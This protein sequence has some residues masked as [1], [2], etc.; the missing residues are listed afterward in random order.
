MVL[1]RCCLRS[2]D[3]DMTGPQ[4]RSTVRNAPGIL[5]DDKSGRYVVRVR[6]RQGKQLSKTFDK[7]SDAKD[8]QAQ[9]RLTP[10]TQARRR[11]MPTFAAYADTIPEMHP[12]WRPGTVEAW[13]SR[14]NRVRDDLGPIRLDV[15][16]AGDVR[17]A[18]A[19]MQVLGRAD[20]TIAATRGLV[21]AV[22]RHALEDELVDS[23]PMLRL[24][25]TSKRIDK[26]A[27]ARNSALSR[28]QYAAL[29]AALPESLRTFAALIASTGLRPSEAAGL[30]LDRLDLPN[31]E[32]L[33]DRQLVNATGDRPVFAP[34]KTASSVRR[35]DLSDAIAVLLEQHLAAYGPGTDGL[36]FVTVRRLPLTRRRM[37]E[38]WRQATV[39][40]DLPDAARGWHSLRHT[41]VTAQI[42]AGVPVN[43]VAGAVGH[44]NGGVT[45]SIYSHD[46]RETRREARNAAADALGISATD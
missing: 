25:R 29:V 22:F 19:S 36:V 4:T 37:S 31:R 10:T 18:L 35:V 39:D 21:T 1:S 42:S 9:H 13:K 5:Q 11:E 46:D 26:G 6:D 8:W 20:T 28:E 16:T 30:T 45:L 15:M 43:A 32:I 34:P 33:I 44:A 40:L 17:R 41:A 14:V 3:G 23:S 12:E 38:I 24:G 2:N 7:L 27:S